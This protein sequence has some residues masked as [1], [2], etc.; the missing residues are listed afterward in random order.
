VRSL[1]SF[2]E[3]IYTNKNYFS[4]GAAEKRV[5]ASRFLEKR[6]GYCEY[7][8]IVN[9]ATYCEFDAQFPWK[10]FDFLHKAPILSSSEAE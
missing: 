9:I 6:L 4:F 3:R 2:P 10:S 5:D 1:P 7:S 8:H